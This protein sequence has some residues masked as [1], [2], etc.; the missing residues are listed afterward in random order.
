[1]TNNEY[2]LISIIFEINPNHPKRKET[3]DAMKLF[4]ESHNDWK[5]YYLENDTY[6]SGIRCDNDLLDFLKQEDHINAIQEYFI[7]KLN[8][9]HLIKQ[10]YPDL[11]WKT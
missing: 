2:P 1:M 7:E 6:W 10:Q 3:I 8:E 9:L 11:N 5:G 4:L